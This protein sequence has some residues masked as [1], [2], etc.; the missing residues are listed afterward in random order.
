M[1]A[2]TDGIF[3]TPYP[4]PLFPAVV[5]NENTP[6][7]AR[8]SGLSSVDTQSRSRVAPLHCPLSSPWMSYPFE[9]RWLD[10]MS[11]ATF[12]TGCFVVLLRFS[13][14]T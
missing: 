4:P 6:T 10:M 11:E 2:K 12:E 8:V 13:N 5:I 9:R 14:W 7:E 1:L 3:C